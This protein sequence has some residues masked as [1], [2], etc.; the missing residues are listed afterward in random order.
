[1]LPALVTVLLGGPPIAAP[2]PPPAPIVGGAVDLGDPA[3]VAVGVRR[4]A[5]GELLAPHC[6]GTVIAPRLV[7]TAAHCVADPRLGSDLE[8]LFGHE[9]SAADARVLSVV[10]AVV[11]PDYHA[12]GDAADLALLVLA[13]AA[14]VAPIP[15]AEALPD[16]LLGAEV[17]IVGF[18][19]EGFGTMTGTKRAGT[20]VV[21]A[22]DERTIRTAP[23]PALSCQG[24]S[25]GP[26]LVRVGAGEQL[27]A[28]TVGGDPGCT[29]HGTNVRV[30]PFLAAFIAPA[31]VGT[32]E[33]SSAPTPAIAIDELCETPCT[34]NADC[35]SGLVCLPSQTSG[36]APMSRC[37]VPGA[38][39]GSFGE[40]CSN[41]L[42][43]AGSCLRVH[44]GQTPDA[45]RCYEPCDPPAAQ[46]GG[47]RLASPTVASPWWTVLVILSALAGR[48]R[49]A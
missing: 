17:R 44:S 47:C 27:V 20:S 12:F 31:I 13:E 23:G 45:C 21:T 19:T 25:G 32:M 7:L 36:G 34:Q 16:D 26:V 48:R 18:G 28:V 9:V 24:D 33:K 30:D 46:R 5:C 29:S 38:P 22:I 1:M 3:V 41:D 14:D 40:V 2:E 6:T 8:V 10:E 11:H 42:V 43:C 4:R 37:A 15:L 35:P 49:R 39:A